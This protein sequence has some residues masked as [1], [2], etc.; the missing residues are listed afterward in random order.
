MIE[1]PEIMKPREAAEAIGVKVGT[2]ANWRSTGC[3]NLKWIKAGR[4]IRYRR[5]DVLDF[6]NSRTCG[7]AADEARP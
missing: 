3:Y 4:L 6:I 1:F 2:I 7:G 5:Q